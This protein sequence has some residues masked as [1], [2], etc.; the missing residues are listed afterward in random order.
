MAVSGILTNCL[1]A[2]FFC[3]A[4]AILLTAPRNYLVA[5]FVCGFSGRWVRDIL[6]GWDAGENWSI[7]L[8]AAVIFLVAAALVPRHRAPPVVLVCGV[9]PLGAAIAAFNTIFEL[10]K[11]S[12]AKGDALNSASVAFTSNLAKVLIVTLSIALG[13]STGAAIMKVFR[14]DDAVDG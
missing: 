2:G 11:L 5:T 13:I 12:T 6:I 1:W 8:A 3:T 9:L 7:A 4:A 10:I 14:R